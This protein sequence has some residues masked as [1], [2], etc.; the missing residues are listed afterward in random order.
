MTTVLSSGG[1]HAGFRIMTDPTA[2]SSHS[3]HCQSAALVNATRSAY[4]DTFWSI[5]SAAVAC[6]SWL[7][8]KRAPVTSAAIRTSETIAATRANA[9]RDFIARG[10]AERQ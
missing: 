6:V 1:E 3:G 9:G 8:A 10:C 4:V 5:I 7:L 2:I